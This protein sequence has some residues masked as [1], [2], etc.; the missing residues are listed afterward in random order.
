M[1]KVT[2]V[3]STFHLS[4]Y[5]GII[6]QKMIGQYCISLT[7]EMVNLNFKRN[8]YYWHFS[9]RRILWHGAIASVRYGCTKRYIC[10]FDMSRHRRCQGVSVAAHRCLGA[11]LMH[12]LAFQLHL[13]LGMFIAVSTVQLPIRVSYTLL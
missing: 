12:G 9:I 1:S 6:Y 7:V 3:C 8:I 2:I 4:M 10:Q 5:C 13:S 11:A